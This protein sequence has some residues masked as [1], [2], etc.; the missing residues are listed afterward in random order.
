VKAQHP[1]TTGWRLRLRWLMVSMLAVASLALVA[2][3]SDDSSDTASTGEAAATS[4]AAAD[5]G[6]AGGAVPQQVT[7]L[8]A[9]Y[10]GVPEFKAPGPAFDAKQASGKKIFNIP[11]STSIPFIQTI[12][13][14]MATVAK[15]YGIELIEFTNEGKPTEWAQGIQQAINQKADLIVLQGAPEPKILQPQL[16]AAKKANIPVVVTHWYDAT[17]PLPP[18]VTAQVPVAFS[19]GAQL[20]AAWAIS[21]TEGKANALVVQSAEAPPSAPMVAAIEE[22]F[23]ACAECKLTVV[24][25]PIADW[26][27]KVQTTVQ[28]ALVKDPSIN[29]VIPLYDAMAPF[30]ATAITASGK[31]G[32]VGVATLNGTPA[33]LKLIQDGDIVRMDVGESLDWIGWANMDQAMRILTGNDPVENE[34]TALRVFSKDNVDEAGTPPAVD[35]GYGD[36]Y[37]EGYTK[38]W[39]GE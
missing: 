7:D 10:S 37:V 26:A 18:N 17:Q 20:E 4:T 6:D 19:T 35:K 30:A 23:K 36:A 39:S 33:V 15:K 22:Q 14:A 13:E 31:T 29:Y 34:N 25:V 27:T 12:D 3:G 28:S 24:D 1:A 38:L 11:I 21:D 9:E 2:C 16:K 5:S 32:Q 8:L